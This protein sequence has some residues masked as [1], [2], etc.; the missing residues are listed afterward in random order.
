MDYFTLL[1][2]LSPPLTTVKSNDYS[3]WNF[4]YVFAFQ[5]P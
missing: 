5:S 3:I 4:S 2:I 1:K